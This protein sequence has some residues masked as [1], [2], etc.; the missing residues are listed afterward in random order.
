M[1]IQTKEKIV[2]PAESAA[3]ALLAS[4]R[5]CHLPLYLEKGK[6]KHKKWLNRKQKHSAF[7]KI[8]L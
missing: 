4:A 1:R 3:A 7:S 8:Y 5:W 6:V 2:T